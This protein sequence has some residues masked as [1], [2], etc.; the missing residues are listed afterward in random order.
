V[1]VWFDPKVT[2][3]EELLSLA[4]VKDC[5]RLVWTRDKQH[6]AIADK[7]LAEKSLSFDGPIRLDGEQKYYLIQSPLAKLPM[8][9]AQACRVNARIR[10][11][12]WQEFLSP[13]QL[14][15]AKQLIQAAKDAQKQ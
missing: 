14:L 2:T 1:E 7:V 4:R 6:K 5:A 15:Q 12:G 3:F 9:E 8:S 11:K 10:G 13:Q